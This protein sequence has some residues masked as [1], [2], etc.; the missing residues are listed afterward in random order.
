MTY[1]GNNVLSVVSV[2]VAATTST[3]AASINNFNDD[4]S[5]WNWGT[6]TQFGSGEKVWPDYGGSGSSDSK[7]SLAIDQINDYHFTGTDGQT[8]E[9]RFG[10]NGAKRG[11]RMGAAI[12]WIQIMDAFN[13]RDNY[14]DSI[15]NT[16]QGNY[17]DK[18]NLANSCFLVQPINQFAIDMK[19]D[20]IDDTEKIVYK[21]DDGEQYVYLIAG[22]EGCGGDAWKGSMDVGNS[23]SNSASATLQAPFVNNEKYAIEQVCEAGEDMPNQLNNVCAAFCSQYDDATSNWHAP[24]NE[25]DY[26][27]KGSCPLGISATSNWGQNATATVE[28]FKPV[29]EGEDG[30]YTHCNTGHVN[31]CSGTNMHF[32]A[33]NDNPIWTKDY[34]TTRLSNLNHDTLNQNIMVRWKAVPCDIWG[35]WDAE[36][37]SCDAKYCKTCTKGDPTQCAV[38]ND[39][40][41]P[42]VKQPD[43]SMACPAPP[44]PTCPSDCKTC[45]GNT[46]CYKWT[47]QVC[48]EHANE[49]YVWC[50]DN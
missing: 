16:A 7:K 39:G 22:Y 23:C 48:E 24:T 37:Q 38:C 46:A 10:L 14:V 1:N 15:I 5:G 18:T 30:D 21:A 25:T 36:Y 45:Y 34:K 41:P 8:H 20:D 29:V 35:E 13:G 3:Y 40:N 6:T 42:S 9:S 17:T 50:G 26:V 4:T 31:Y 2:I 27:L 49:N 28:Y 19:V 47:K 43:G 33:A 32:D 11:G 12:P 44:K